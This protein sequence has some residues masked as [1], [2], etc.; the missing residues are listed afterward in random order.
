M[1]Q[2]IFFIIMLFIIFVP[3]IIGLLRNKKNKGNNVVLLNIILLIINILANVIRLQYFDVKEVGS[4]FHTVYGIVLFLIIAR[5]L[6]KDSNIKEK[7]KSFFG[8]LIV[9]LIL[10]LIGFWWLEW[11]SLANHNLLI[12]SEELVHSGFYD[13]AIFMNKTIIIA[14]TLLFSSVLINTFIRVMFKDKEKL[15]NDEQKAEDK[16]EE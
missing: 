16:L 3:L 9:F 4:V 1:I 12:E 5:S 7:N 14:E 15:T 13:E 2:L 10:A 8:L 6:S 11:A